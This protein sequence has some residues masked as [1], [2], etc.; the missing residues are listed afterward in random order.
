MS[1]RALRGF[2]SMHRRKGGRAP[3]LRCVLGEFMHAGDGLYSVRMASERIDRSKLNDH[4]R[5]TCSR[6]VQ[7][8]RAGCTAETPDRQD[9]HL[10]HWMMGAGWR[11][12]LVGMK[13]R[14][15]AAR[16]GPVYVVG[17]RYRCTER[18]AWA[19]YLRSIIWRV[20]C[21]DINLQGPSHASFLP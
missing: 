19:Y 18:E 3:A 5:S 2:R 9:R 15:G 11:V 12:S 1:G 14:R 21:P 7:C 17:V 20:M 8:Q 13:E 6:I 4:V 16:Q 10:A